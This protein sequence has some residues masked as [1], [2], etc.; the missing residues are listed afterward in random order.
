MNDPVQMNT[1]IHLGVDNIITD[2][3]DLLV[4]LLAERAQLSKTERIILFLGDI[5]KGRL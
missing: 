1:M 5:F 2:R 4:D 3:P